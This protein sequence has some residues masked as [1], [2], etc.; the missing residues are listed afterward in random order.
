MLGYFFI[1]ALGALLTTEMAKYRI[2]RLRPFFLTA[3]KVE[4]TDALCKDQ[5]GY[6]KFVTEY[7]VSFFPQHFFQ[8]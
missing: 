3:C 2:G 6:N 4:L 7:L 8:M 1:G 5:F